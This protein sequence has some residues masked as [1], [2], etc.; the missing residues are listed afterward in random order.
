MKELDIFSIFENIEWPATKQDL[1][2]YATDN[3]FVEDIFNI[4]NN[5]DVGDDY[6]FSSLNDF[7]ENIDGD[8][9]FAAGSNNLDENIVDE[10]FDEE[11][12]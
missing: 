8:D 3:G 4:I 1:L 12:F 11:N 7:M 9:D 5:I 2:Q 6:Y 10:N